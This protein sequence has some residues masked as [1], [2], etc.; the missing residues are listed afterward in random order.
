MNRNLFK[1]VS[2]NILFKLVDVCI[3]YGQT[4]FSQEGEDLIL[5]RYFEGKT[6]GFFV[7][8]GAHHPIRF[9]NTYHFYRRG[10]RGMVVQHASLLF[11]RAPHH[12]HWPAGRQVIAHHPRDVAS[13]WGRWIERRPGCRGGWSALRHER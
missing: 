1:K 7:D 12:R 13:D 2:R 8:I 9:S 4:S 11:D 3:P 10:W 5:Q 6:K